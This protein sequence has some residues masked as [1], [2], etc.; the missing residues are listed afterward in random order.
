LNEWNNREN[1]DKF[2]ELTYELEFSV[3][4]GKCCLFK[5][6]ALSAGFI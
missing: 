1:S 5:R 2:Y 4:L 6:L 3:F